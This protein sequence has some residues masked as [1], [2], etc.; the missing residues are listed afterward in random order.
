V[1]TQLKL[2][3]LVPVATLER[4]RAL[5]ESV[6]GVPVVFTDSEGVPLTDIEDRAGSGTYLSLP[7]KQRSG[8]SEKVTSQSSTIAGEDSVTQRHLS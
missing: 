4:L 7:W 3:E 8:K 6:T 2:A 1:E 5:F